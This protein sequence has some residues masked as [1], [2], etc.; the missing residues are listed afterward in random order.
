MIKPSV[1]NELAKALIEERRRKAEQERLARAVRMRTRGD[2]TWPSWRLPGL[3]RWGTVMRS[4][5]PARDAD[6]ARGRADVAPAARVR[7]TSAA[8]STPKPAAL[9]KAHARSGGRFE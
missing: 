2:R 3:P 8:E 5:R 6:D 1:T 9:V 7:A 4:L